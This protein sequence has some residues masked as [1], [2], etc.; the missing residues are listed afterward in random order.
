[1]QAFATAIGLLGKDIRY[2]KPDQRIDQSLFLFL[3]QI[4]CGAVNKMRTRRLMVTLIAGSLLAGSGVAQTS[5]G[6]LVGVARD[7]S[8]AVVPNATVTIVGNSDGATRS[9]QTKADG[10]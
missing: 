5:K 10:S 1:L 6:I 7:A 4:P 9:V 8:D 2:H 3:M